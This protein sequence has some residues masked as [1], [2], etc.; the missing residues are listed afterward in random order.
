MLKVKY[1]GIGGTG[2]DYKCYED[3]EGNIFFKEH[4]RDIF[5]TGTYRDKYDDICGEPNER[6]KWKV[7]IVEEFRHNRGIIME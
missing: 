3:K 7:A 5:Y 4:Y 6:V 1:V 2:L